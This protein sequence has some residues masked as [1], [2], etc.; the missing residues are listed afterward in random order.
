MKNN[1]IKVLILTLFF[2]ISLFAQE[3]ITLQLKWFH[4]FQFAGYYAAKEKGFYKEV[5]LDVEIKQRDL[6]KN[7]IEEVLNNDSYYGIADSILLLYKSRKKSVV[8]VSPIFQHSASVLLSLKNNKIDSPYKLDN[9]DMLFYENDTDGFTLLA[10][11][12]KL[13]VKPNL[14][15]KR[16]KDD[17]KKI[18]DGKVDVMP[19]YIS[20]EPYYFKKKN[21]DINI[22]NPANYGFD[23]YGDMIFTSK[24]E[25]Q[26]NPSRVEKFKE[27]TLRGWKYALENKEEVIKLIIQKYSKRKSVEHLRL[28]AAAIDRLISKDIIPLGSLDKGRLKYINDIFKEYSKEK[29]NDLDFE[30]FVFEKDFDKFNFTKEELEFIKNN[31]V[32][33]VQNLSFFPPYNFVENGKPK[34]FI[35]DYLNYISSLTNMKFQ[36]VN[37]SSWSSYEKM[38]KNKEIDIIPNIAIT[39]NRKKYVLY[40]NFNYISYSPAIVGDKNIN[41]N[42]KLEDLE[43]KI[44]AVLNNSFLHNLIKKN[45]P[46]LTLLAVPSSSKAVEMVLENKADLALG[47]LSTLQY[48]VQKNWYTNLK[49]LKLSSNIIPTKVNLHMG[50]LKDN[51]LL[52]SIFEKINSTISISTIDKIQDKWSKLEIEKNNLV[53]TE[54]EKNYLDNKKEIKVCVDPEWMPFEKIKDNKLLGMSSDYLKIFENKLDIPFTLVSTKSWTKTLNN[55]ENRSCDLIP[56]ISEEEKRKQYLDFSKAYLSF[57]LVL[58]T[59]LEEPFISNVSDTYGEKLGYIKDYAYVSILEKKYPKI[60]LVEVE[61]M[62]VGLEKVKNKELFGLVGILPSI[63]YYVQK[64]YFGDLK[65]SGKFDDDWS[66]S[67]GS[68]NDETDLNSIMNKVLETITVQEHKKIYENWVAVKY[69]ENIDYRKIIAISSFLMLIIFIILY[70]N[71]TI[72]SINRKMRKYLDIIDKNVLT[73]S[74]DT[75]GNI[76]YVSK[77]FLNISQFKK[78]ELIGK[79]HNIVR[80]KDMNNIVFKDLWDTIESGKEWKGEIKN[81]KK[82]GGYFWTNTVITPEFNKGK[83]VS[84]T[85]IREDITDKKIIEEISITDGLTDIYNRRH[86]DKILPDY[87]NNAKRNNEIITFVMMDIDHFKQYNDNYGH[88]K[89]DEV[90]IDVAKVLTEYMKR[91][92]DYCFRLGGEEFGLLYKSNDIS[93]SKEFALKILNGIEKMK[94]KHKYN[95]VSDYITVSM[96]VSCQE[97]SSISNVDNLYKTTDDLLYKSKKEGR[98]RVSFNT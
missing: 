90:L 72:N 20:N 23:F 47:N 65:V 8:L 19:A 10:L 33:K 11:L 83:L 78:E 86:F 39:E 28:E 36:F 76:T 92:D 38:L 70:K 50:Y 56:M 17:Y 71:R 5:G 45:Y 67:V 46:N 34:G 41:F 6:S 31:P 52:K 53:L 12:K 95:S 25:V 37:S 22:I 84:Y 60:Q 93:K 43:D 74:T 69:E 88:Q 64:D 2:S 49:T 85:A 9:K 32:L 54:K 51:I 91:A 68:R 48:I 15:R 66:F 57:P 79:N 3:K 42:N 26:N 87:I 40:S 1:I 30:S 63:G 97:A 98:N 29:I 94:I 14:I 35:V 18:I 80:H 7:Y 44:I 4:Q 82:D 62:K 81:K 24:K 61:S 75:K 73:T 58:A 77:A 89:G 27:A 96:G 55:L 21:L 59:R 16:E 13:N